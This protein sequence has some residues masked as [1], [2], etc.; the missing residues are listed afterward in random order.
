MSGETEYVGMAMA[1][2][3]ESEA[4]WQIQKLTYDVDDNLIALD[5]ANDSDKFQFVWDNKE[6]YF[7]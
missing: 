3:L 7:A 1:D 2:A 6:S 4:K 5:F